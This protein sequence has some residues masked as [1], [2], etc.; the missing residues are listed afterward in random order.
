MSQPGGQH[1]QRVRVT[2]SRRGTQTASRRTVTRAL[3][4][5]TGVGELY[6]RDLLRAQ[7]RLSLTV[8]GATAVLLLGLP[9]LLALAPQTRQLA[10]GGVPL[11]WVLLGVLV[12]PVLVLAA[13]WFVRGAERTER[14]FAEVVGQEEG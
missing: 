5:Q 4:E 6:L 10:I 1:P 3:V 13:A 11:T 12:Y 9:L 8:I 7:L 2:S 14:R